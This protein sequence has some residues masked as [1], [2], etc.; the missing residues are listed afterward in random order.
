[1]EYVRDEFEKEIE[2]GA[3]LDEIKMKFMEYATDF[4]AVFACTQ[5]VEIIDIYTEG[6]AKLTKPRL[7]FYF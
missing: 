6:W 3:T 1:M 5:P 4:P 7:V 2:N